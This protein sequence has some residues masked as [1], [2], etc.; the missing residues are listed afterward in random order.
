[1]NASWAPLPGRGA[2]RWAI[3]VSAAAMGCGVAWLA[4]TTGAWSLATVLSFL[5]PGVV[6]LAVCLLGYRF[7][8][9]DP[10]ASHAQTVLYWFLLGIVTNTAIGLWYFAIQLLDPAALSTPSA[11]L[12]NVATGGLFGVVV[13]WYSVRARKTTE[14]ATRAKARRAA[15]ERQR[16]TLGVLD[17]ALRHYLL[18]ALN[19]IGAHAAILEDHT[20]SEAEHH[21]AVIARRTEETT[22]TVTDIRRVAEALHDSGDFEPVDLVGEIEACVD[23]LR[24]SNPEATIETDSLADP[25][26]IAGDHLL[27]VAL[28][29]V[30]ENAIDHGGECPTVTVTVD[31]SG[32]Y[33]T[34]HVTDDGPG[35]PD[36]RKESIFEMAEYGPEGGVGMGLFLVRSIVDRY[37]GDVGVADVDPSG[38]RFSLRFPMACAPTS[39]PS[40]SRG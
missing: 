40:S 5:L 12:T 29:E 30:V 28:A 37:G 3:P 38:A 7:A 36:A 33:A 1:V 2:L 13:G 26:E 24:E 27:E 39:R 9:S 17:R 16:E 35:V 25:V 15:L 20:D 22:E 8:R 19:V 23:R 14:E 18:N 4:L 32:D 21:R 6:I 31:T 10:D 11:L 34:V